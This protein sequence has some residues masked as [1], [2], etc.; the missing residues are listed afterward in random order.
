MISAR[1]T[2]SVILE[3]GEMKKI[4]KLLLAT[5][6]VLSVGMFYPEMLPN[7]GT[8]QVEAAVKINSKRVTL[9]K[10]QKTNLR[11][12]DTKKKIKWSSN[13]K[14]VATVNS[15]GR[16]AAKKKGVATITAKIGNKNYKCKVTV[17][18]PS[19]N[20][21]TASLTV[22]KKTTIK[23]NGTTQKIKWQ[24]S[25]TKVAT[26]NSKGKVTAKRAGKATITATVLNKKY[27]CRI[28]VSAKPVATKPGTQTSTQPES[29]PAHVWK[30]AT[31]SK[32]HRI[33]N[34]GTMNP[35]KAKRI[36]LAEAKRAGLGP[37]SKCF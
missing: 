3:E 26:V 17:E 37:C 1:I 34:C 30:S 31:G 5:M 4:K 24:S 29:T 2:A 18:T 20:K 9:I 6:I 21:K 16:V 15:K 25:N 8:A 28:T 11:I 36:T 23:M 10:G 33:N 14:A 19:I 22:G 35:S 13:N 12:T 27:T 32:Y 7:L